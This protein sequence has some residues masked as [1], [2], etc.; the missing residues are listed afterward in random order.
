MSP[1]WQGLGGSQGT[2]CIYFS[3]ESVCVPLLSHPL[4]EG[5]AGRAEHW[6]ILPASAPLANGLVA[7]GSLP[8][9]G[10]QR[11]GSDQPWGPGPGGAPCNCSNGLGF[12]FSQQA[13]HEALTL[14]QVSSWSADGPAPGLSSAPSLVCHRNTLSNA[15][16]VCSP[17][18]HWCWFWCDTVQQKK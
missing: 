17:A 11:W 8:T 2:C 1:G 4:E 15:S 14:S 18:S 3:R 6:D 5:P 12:L 10:K 16:R 7:A 13:K 9:A